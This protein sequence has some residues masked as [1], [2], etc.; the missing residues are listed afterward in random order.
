MP[1]LLRVDH[2][3]SFLRWRSLHPDRA[4]AARGRGRP[5][6]G[7]RSVFHIES[8]AA[9]LKWSVISIARLSALLGW[10]FV[11]SRDWHAR[12]RRSRSAPIAMRPFFLLL[13]GGRLDNGGVAGASRSDR[14]LRSVRSAPTPAGIDVRSSRL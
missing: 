7:A 14:L 2:H 9:K 12:P 1:P 10:P 4:G 5:A 11:C 3:I 6:A 8:L 13:I